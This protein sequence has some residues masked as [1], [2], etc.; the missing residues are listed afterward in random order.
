MLWSAIK[1]HKRKQSEDPSRLHQ[2]PCNLKH[3]SLCSGDEAPRED[4]VNG[5]ADLVL[6]VKKPLPERQLEMAMKSVNS[7]FFIDRIFFCS[8]GG[9]RSGIRSKGIHH[10]QCPRK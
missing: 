7:G 6:E 10:R 4:K 3:R 5:K 9:I 2:L 1:V 8:A